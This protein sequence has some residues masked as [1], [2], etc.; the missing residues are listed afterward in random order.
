[1]MKWACLSSRSWTIR[2]WSESTSAGVTLPSVLPQW[3]APSF[4]S[5]A[6][7][8][9]DED[10]KITTG[11]KGLAHRQIKQT[12]RNSNCKIAKTTS[13]KFLCCQRSHYF[14]ELKWIESRCMNI[15]SASGDI[16]VKSIKGGRE[17]DL[18]TGG[19]LL[20]R[21]L[22]PVGKQSN[23]KWICAFVKVKSAN[24]GSS[25]KTTRTCLSYMWEW[26]CVQGVPEGSWNR[27]L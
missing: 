5:P 18:P 3:D 10:Q 20:R 26:R 7:L 19:R 25:Q 16:F 8:Q 9:W 23:L 1:M 4:F 22:V 27:L 12:C 6:H 21:R 11:R 14:T 13:L 17:W 15:S 2:M 24:P